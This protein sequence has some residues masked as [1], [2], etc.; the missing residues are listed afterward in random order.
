MTAS[1]LAKRGFSL[2]NGRRTYASKVLTTTGSARPPAPV[3]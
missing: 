1:S 2:V 3:R